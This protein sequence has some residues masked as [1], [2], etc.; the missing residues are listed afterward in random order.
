MAYKYNR[1]SLTSSEARIQVP[2]V[3]VTFKSKQSDYTFGIFTSQTKGRY[4]DADGFWFRETYGVRYPNY[5][6]SLSV[7]KING[8]VNQY[9][10]NITYPIT[11]NDDPNFFEK[12]FSA[13]S[14]TRKIIF[15]YGDAA[16]PSF[17][18]KD[19]EAIITT[20]TQTFN[21]ESSC[22]KY[23]VNA[24]SG[25]ALNTPACLS[26]PAAKAKPSTK[27]KEVFKTYNLG[28]VFTGMNDKNWYKLVAGDDA[29][30]DIEAK[31]NISAIDYIIYLVSC[32]YPVGQA[33]TNDPKSIYVLT[34]HDESSY[35][36]Y[37]TYN[38][39]FGEVR[40]TDMYN[41]SLDL[42]GPYFKVSKVSYNTEKSDAYELDIGYNNS[43][44]VRQ[45]SIENNENYAIYYDH[46]MEL[47][48]DTYVRH[49]N[50]NGKLEDVYAPTVSS[51]NEEFLT[52]AEDQTWWTKV[53]QFPINATITV[54]GLLRPARLL[55]YIR[56]NVIF[57][58]G[59]KHISSGLYIITKQ[60]DTINANGYT[61][62]LNMTRVG[63]ALLDKQQ[64]GNTTSNTNIS[65]SFKAIN[66]LTR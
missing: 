50:N 33:N 42:L 55:T 66:R 35:D 18:Y 58:G 12:I 3:K 53:T 16:T 40:G 46:Q 44:I 43:T 62:L 57:P 31:V 14:D 15:T 8:Q 63:G 1:Y 51:K 5:I 36:K 26:F 28:S 21:L 39:S 4:K 54:Q 11:Q 25:A 60:V 47:A 24:V 7:V 17:V 48:R 27:I 10:L 37:Y 64:S 52:R 20:I 29:V 32:M 22:I 38:G 19:E 13:V 23:T 56:L 34:I 30:V 61:T 49:I 9:T 45:F 6:E 2:W 65:K 41:Q 59:H